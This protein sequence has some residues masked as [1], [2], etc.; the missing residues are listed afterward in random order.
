MFVSGC[1][2][3]TQHAADQICDPNLR[4]PRS[5]IFF[6]S[7][8]HNTIPHTLLTKPQKNRLAAFTPTEYKKKIIT[9]KTIHHR[10]VEPWQT[11]LPIKNRE[12]PSP[13]AHQS[14]ARGSIG[15]VPAGAFTPSYSLLAGNKERARGAAR[16][17]DPGN[18]ILARGRRGRVHDFLRGVRKR[19]RPRD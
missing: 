11:R 16:Q 6:P 18:P 10:R 13:A 19:K 8:I 5:Y 9:S 17:M 14:V 15:P 2:S 4:L 1:D 12:R 7:E 3:N